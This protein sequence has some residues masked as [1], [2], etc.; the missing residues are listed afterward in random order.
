MN[1][2]I[3]G[4][5]HPLRVQFEPI[6]NS[7]DKIYLFKIENISYPYKEIYLNISAYDTYFEGELTINGREQ[8]GDMN[9]IP[10]YKATTNKSYLNIIKTRI[11]ENTFIQASGISILFIF[12][13]LIIFTFSYLFIS[14][15]N[16]NPSDNANKK[17]S[18]KGI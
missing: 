13:I 15:I 1:Q 14:N 10:V 7:R 11:S 12:L 16:N 4:E 6:N 18:K 8:S 2:Q 3:Q 17:N 9:F 5:T